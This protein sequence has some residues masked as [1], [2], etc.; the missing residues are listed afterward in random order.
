MSDNLISVE[1]LKSLT[2]NGKIS[3]D[4]I[5]TQLKLME[6]RQNYLDMHT[7]KLW[8]A[9]DGYWKTKIKESDGH[10]RL[11]RKSVV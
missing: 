11:D 3:V 5:V 4:A 8:L 1:L 7:C 2:G 10:Y 6:S 9:S